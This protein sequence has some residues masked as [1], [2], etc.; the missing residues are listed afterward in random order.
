MARPPRLFGA[1]FFG[2]RPFGAR[3]FAAGRSSALVVCALSC[4]P[5]PFAV[6]GLATR[7]EPAARDLGVR[8]AHLTLAPPAPSVPPLQHEPSAP[9]F[10]ELALDPAPLTDPRQQQGATL[11]R[12][13]ATKKSQAAGAAAASS[14]VSPA[15]GLLVRADTVLRLARAGVVP[16]ASPVAGGSESPA[17]M[18]LSGV[19]ALGVGLRD[20]DVLTHVLGQPATSRSS[21][22]SLVLQA[23]ARREQRISAVFW[24][25]GVPWQLWVEMPYLRGG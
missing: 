22:V 25:G 11:K 1:G 2:A 5:W 23:R 18:R 17:G 4:L 3:L 13:G 21:V 15:R 6:R 8:L 10:E 7:A 12:S 9:P 14:A 20:G 19:S 24:R 16:A